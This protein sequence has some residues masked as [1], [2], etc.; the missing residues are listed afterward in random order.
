ME[1]LAL[2]RKFVWFFPAVTCG[3][4]NIGCYILNKKKKKKKK[5]KKETPHAFLHA[6]QQKYTLFGYRQVCLL[7]DRYQATRCTKLFLFQ[8]IAEE[9]ANFD[10]MHITISE[11]R[12]AHAQTLYFLLGRLW[13]I[14]TNQIPFEHDQILQM[15]SRNNRLNFLRL[16]S[17]LPCN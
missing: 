8:P 1:S 7:C 6:F 15:V 5:K 17:C 14:T 12:S 4:D 2:F 13:A 10:R 3:V 16:R 11:T 9:L